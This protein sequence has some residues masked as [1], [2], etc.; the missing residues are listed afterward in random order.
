[1]HAGAA[2]IKPVITK[3]PVLDELRLCFTSPIGTVK[4]VAR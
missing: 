3:Y 1:V 2:K 4:S